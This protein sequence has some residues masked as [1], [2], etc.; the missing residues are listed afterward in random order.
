M[1]GLPDR[2][3]TVSELDKE[4]RNSRSMLA[5]LDFKKLDKTIFDEWS[6][7][8]DQTRSQSTQVSTLN[9]A[10]DCQN[11]VEAHH[12]ERKRCD[13]KERHSNRQYVR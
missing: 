6:T 13:A 12:K 9:P 4:V 11:C 3:M 7:I 5:N 2:E 1:S 10:A 8:R